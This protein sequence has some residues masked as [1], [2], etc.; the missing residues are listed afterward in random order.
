MKLIRTIAVSLFS[1]WLASACAISYPEN[2]G[3]LRSDVQFASGTGNVT[4]LLKGS[5]ATLVGVV[6][7]RVDA[8]KAVKAA[9][10]SEGIDKVVDYITVRN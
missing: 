9:Q 6:N 1:V 4:V 3:T 5:T 7:S 8:N 2:L 10:E